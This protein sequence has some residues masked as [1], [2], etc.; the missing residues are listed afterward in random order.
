MS[1]YINNMIKAARSGNP[2]DFDTAFK[3]EVQGRVADRITDMRADTVAGMLG[4]D[5]KESIELED[6]DALVESLTDEELSI[7]EGLD[8]SEV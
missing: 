1:N 6:V 4:V 2:T 7:I 8:E 5:F 3:S